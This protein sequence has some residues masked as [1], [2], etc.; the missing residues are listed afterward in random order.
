MSENLTPFAAEQVCSYPC[1]PSVDEC[2]ILIDKPL[3][4]TSF[5]VVRKLRRILHVKK[6]G[7]A[8]TLDPMATGLLICLVG[9]ATKR[10]EHFMG[11]TK[12]Y[13]GMLRLGEVTPS[14]DAE[15]EV[16][17]RRDWRH[18]TDQNLEAA[19]MQL[20]GDID[21]IPPMF[22][23]VK[24]GGERL[25]KKARRGE[26]IERK[27]RRITIYDFDLL[28]ASMPEVPFRVRCSK[29]TYVRSLVHDFGA[30]LGVGAH[31]TMLRR[32]AIGE[33]DVVRAW[34]MS[35]LELA[36]ADHPQPTASPGGADAKE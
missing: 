26:E 22:S 27:P 21:Q 5:D 31:L 15:S 18:L 28:N 34:D 23:A 6:V 29:G 35:E 24:V 12:T 14:Y 13:D 11:L 36:L 32:T 17:E 4:W 8:G 25:Y 16:V 20:L 19:R 1:L 3:G 30:I 10:M 2:V 33:Y 7:H 9:R